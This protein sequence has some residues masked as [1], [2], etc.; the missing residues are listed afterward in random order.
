MI[1]CVLLAALMQAGAARAR[2]QLND[3]EV[4][5]VDPHK[6]YIFYRSAEKLELRFFREVS[7][8]QQSK[9]DAARAEA[10]A[11]ARAKYEKNFAQW[12]RDEAD[13][14]QLSTGER[15]RTIRPVRPDPVT[16]ETFPYRPI[17][18]DNFVT[19]SSGPQFTKGDSGYTYLIAVEPGT[20]RIYGQLVVTQQGAVGSCLCM[21]S[22]KFEAR[23]GQIVDLGEITY[24]RF[25]AMKAH[26]EVPRFGRLATVAVVPAG[27]A[28]PLPD[29]LAGR[30][31]VRA[32]FRAADKM[33]NYF[34]VQIDRIP[35][36]PGVLG[37]QRDRIV[38]LK[39][40]GLG[41]GGAPR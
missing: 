14:L 5:T 35:A 41:T 24:P 23:P 38:D 2:D 33:P 13:Y 1:G 22:V 36:M 37:Y 7:P 26:R 15:G 8:A 16:P 17:E 27:A 20:Y 40:A 28:A 9:Y 29:R 6:S 19:I 31:V 39:A 11:K 34:G 4:V 32:D 3:K 21:G 25:E 18:L 10:Y 30:P 12:K